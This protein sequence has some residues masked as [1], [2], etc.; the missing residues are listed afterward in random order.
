MISTGRT[1][2]YTGGVV[3]EAGREAWESISV[4]FWGGEM[5]ARFREASE[6]IDLTPGLMK[7]LFHLEQDDGVPMRELADHCGCD[8]SYV[9]T[10]VDGLEEKGYA[11]RR[12]HP[13]DRRVKAIALTEAG[14][15]AKARAMAILHAPPA[16][17]DVLGAAE[18]RQLRD[19]VRKIAGAQPARGP[20]A[21]SR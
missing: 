16:A 7:S 10:I 6:R 13:T 3:T 15:E 18:Q 5:Q 4:L 12:P 19:L 11:E 21:A 20:D 2:T 17:L 9:T 14:A 1:S 8:A